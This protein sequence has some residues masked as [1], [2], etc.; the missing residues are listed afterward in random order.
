VES[1]IAAILCVYISAFLLFEASPSRATINW[2]GRDT[3]PRYIMRSLA[4]VMLM[5]AFLSIIS[6]LGTIRG[7]PIWIGLTAATSLASI[8]IANWRTGVHHILI[9]LAAAGLVFTS[10]I[11]VTG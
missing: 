2:P 1:I 11:A 8:L 4:F 6:V 5:T 10:L 7:I 3:L 9:G